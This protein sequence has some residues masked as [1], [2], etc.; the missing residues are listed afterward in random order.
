MTEYIIPSYQGNFRSEKEAKDGGIYVTA[1]G[2][3]AAA[4]LGCN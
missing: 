4:Y 2:G 1:L 3:L